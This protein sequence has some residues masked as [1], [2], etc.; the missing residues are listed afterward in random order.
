MLKPTLKQKRRVK[1]K[2][3]KR[4]IIKKTKKISSKP[5]KQSLN[6]PKKSAKAKIHK[7]RK[8]ITN[9]SLEN[10]LLDQRTPLNKNVLDKATQSYL[11]LYGKEYNS[12]T[13]IQKVFI[14]NN[15]KSIVKITKKYYR[16]PDIAKRFGKND[17]NIVEF[18]LHPNGDIANLRISKK[19]K[20]YF[21]DKSILEAIEVAYKDYPKPKK[22]TKIKFYVS[23]KIY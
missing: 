18:I 9:K 12:F 15:I 14:Q 6:N 7:K 4:R 3:K 23:Y 16:F 19:G 11:E 17:F 21:Y 5:E 20:Y 2:I 1:S 13:K 22:A 8:K 10:F